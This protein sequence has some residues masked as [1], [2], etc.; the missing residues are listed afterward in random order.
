MSPRLKRVT[1]DEMCR[2][3]ERDGWEPVRITR[4]RNYQKIIEG[5][6]VVVQ[7]PNHGP[8]QLRVGTQ[9]AIMRKAQISAERLLELL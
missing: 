9:R 1:C 2:I 5:Q 7:A 6:R 3:L 8:K 4:H